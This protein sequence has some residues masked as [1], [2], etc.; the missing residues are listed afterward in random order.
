MAYLSLVHFTARFERKQLQDALQIG[1][2]LVPE[3][4]VKWKQSEPSNN[5]WRSK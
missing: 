5:N 3:L 1:A 4:V 2:R